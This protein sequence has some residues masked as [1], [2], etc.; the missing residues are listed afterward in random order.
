MQLQS[1]KKIA[2][3][4]IKVLVYGGAGSGKTRLCSTIERPLIIS[5]ESGLLSLAD[6]DLPYIEISSLRELRDVY[7]FVADSGEADQFDWICLDSISEIAEVVLAHE[8]KNNKDPRAAYGALLD[9][10]LAISKTFRDLSGKNVYVSAKAER[11]QDENGKLVF[12]PS[13][14]GAKLAQQ[15]PYLFDEVFALRVDKDEEGATKRWLQTEASWD[16]VAKDRS[17]KLDP[18]EASDLGAIA[19][20]IINN[21]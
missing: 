20:K 2:S 14:P 13:M 11:Q 17:G 10:V 6:L 19:A 21:N 3:Q 8:K 12:C 18:F 1:T 16:Y 9:Q 7:S 4:G 5:C 15:M